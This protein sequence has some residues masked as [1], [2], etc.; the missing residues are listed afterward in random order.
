M[1]RLV[2]LMVFVGG[3]GVLVWAIVQLSGSNDLH[4]R[5]RAVSSAQWAR[6]LIV[7]F[8]MT[9]VNGAL[10]RSL[11]RHFRIRL[12]P[13]EWGGLMFVTSFLNTLT[14]FR[15]GAAA[16]ALYLKRHHGLPFKSFLTTLAASGAFSLLVNIAFT[17]VAF[18]TLC[19]TGHPTHILAI[20][21]PALGLT[22][23]LLPFAAGRRTRAE[24]AETGVFGSIIS[25]WLSICQSTS[26]LANQLVFHAVHAV[27][28]V[29]LFYFALVAV[30]GSASLLEVTALAS[31]A[32]VVSSLGPISGGL[33]L[34]ELG[35][36]IAAAGCSVDLTSAILATLVIRAGSLALGAVCTVVVSPALFARRRTKRCRAD[37]YK[38]RRSAAI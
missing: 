29:L 7:L 30:G 2:Q 8:C 17:L 22:A 13:I 27:L 32:K 21:I 35:G 16:R 19:L 34:Y 28:N 1:T 18:G 26:L 23:S 9:L 24:S 14:P 10:F 37:S 31:S 5:V 15:A 38:R 20:V 12:S 33:G 36:V 3:I 11:A 4:T 6:L 25:G